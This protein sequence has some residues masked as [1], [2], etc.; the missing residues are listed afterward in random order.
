M[1]SPDPTRKEKRAAARAE[2]EAAERA[3]AAKAQRTRRLQQLGGVLG[4]AAVVVVIAVVASGG[5]SKTVTKKAGEA[6]A[7]QTESG[8]MLAGIPQEGDTLGN[9]DAKVTM[10]EFADL[11][12]PIC[13]EY[14]LQTFPQVV[15]DY[16]RTG[17]V[18]VKFR[19]FTVIGPDSDVA[20]GYAAGAGQQNKLWNFVDL[21][22]FNQGQERSGWVTPAKMTEIGSGVAGLDWARVKAYA[23][24]AAA[25]APLAKATTQAGIYGVQGTPTLVVGPTGGTLTRVDGIDY[26]TV[27]KA[28]DAAL[29]SAGA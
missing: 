7:G 21:T 11:Q 1:S 3:A 26:A 8:Q 2:R 16:V 9:A 6:V 25:K 12:C 5:S 22:Y 4:L 20:W 17:K 19:P 23:D 24:T 29:S 18:K 14:T 10:L 13:R 28:L 27:S 15:Q